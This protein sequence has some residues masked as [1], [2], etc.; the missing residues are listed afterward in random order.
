MVEAWNGRPVK[1]VRFWKQLEKDPD[2]AIKN[3]GKRKRSAPREVHRKNLKKFNPIKI[4]NNLKIASN[5]K[6]FL[7]WTFPLPPTPAKFTLIPLPTSKKTWTFCI[8]EK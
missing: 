5:G 3:I 6:N 1:T 8:P 7:F 2:E 4:Y